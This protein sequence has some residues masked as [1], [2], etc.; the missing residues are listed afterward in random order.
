MRST[1]RTSPSRSIGR[2]ERTERPEIDVEV[3]RCQVEMLTQFGHL[4]FQQHQR[5]AN[6]FDL[7]VRQVTPLDSANRLTL[8]ELPKKLDQRQDQ[9][10]QSLFHRGGIGV[11]SLPR[12]GCVKI[13]A[14]VCHRIGSPPKSLSAAGRSEPTDEIRVRRE[15]TTMSTSAIDKT[16]SPLMT[17]PPASTRSSRSTNAR[18]RSLSAGS[19]SVMTPPRHRR[20]S[21]V[22]TAQ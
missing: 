21:T 2:Q 16:T 14:I 15:I 13:M 6:S 20:M 19:T 22:A 11:D 12:G 18:R 1:T 10:H 17:T 9:A 3:F 8:H 4:F 5:C 7:F